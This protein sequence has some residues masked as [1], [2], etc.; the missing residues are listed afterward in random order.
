MNILNFLRENAR[1]LFAGALLAFLSA[2]G[3]TFFIALFAG[4]IREQFAL[5]L[6]EWG[7][8]YAIG[9]TMS[10]TLMVFAGPLADRMRIRTLGLWVVTGLAFACFAMA[11][12]PN[13]A[14]LILVVLSLRFCGQGMLT[15]LSIVAMARWFVSN[16]GKALAVATLGFSL[17]EAVIPIPTVWIKSMVDWHQIWI[18]AGFFC[19]AMLPL[20]A[21]LLRTERSP[22]SLSEDSSSAG[23]DGKHWKRPETLRHPLFWALAFAGLLTS[24]L[25]TGCQRVSGRFQC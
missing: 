5:S 21:I 13:S 23:M 10:A 2:F 1:W 12:N 24:G 17:G 18:G 20:L 3:Q 6:G 4:E 7:A 14:A 11:A 8:I 19:L 16:R 15:H 25:N 22:K 9:T